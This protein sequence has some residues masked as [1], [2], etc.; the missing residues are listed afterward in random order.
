MIYEVIPMLEWL[1]HSMTTIC[2]AA[3]EHSVICIAAKA[4]LIE[5]LAN[6]IPRVLVPNAL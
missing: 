3:E 5:V 2:N 4:A 6:S 1:E